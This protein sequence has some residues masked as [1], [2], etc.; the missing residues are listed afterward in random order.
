MSFTVGE[1]TLATT[2]KETALELAEAR[3]H[4][5][6]AQHRLDQHRYLLRMERLHG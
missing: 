3:R 2:G 6:A 4:L 5:K 1:F